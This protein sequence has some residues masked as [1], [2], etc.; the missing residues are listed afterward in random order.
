MVIA[1]TCR[2]FVRR[3]R[4]LRRPTGHGYS[5][6]AG[7]SAIWSPNGLAVSRTGRDVGDLARA[8]SS[9]A[10]KQYVPPPS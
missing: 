6:T 7:C 4:E 10:P 1:R 5:E 2:A 3:V 8:P 9:D